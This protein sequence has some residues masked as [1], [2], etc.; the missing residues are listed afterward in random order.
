MDGLFHGLQ[1]IALLLA[2]LIGLPN[3]GFSQQDNTNNLEDETTDGSTN[4]TFGIATPQPWSETSKFPVIFF[5]CLSLVIL[6]ICA[7]GLS[8]CV[9]KARANARPGRRGPPDLSM[10]FSVVLNQRLSESLRSYSERNMDSGIRPVEF[11]WEPATYE[12]KLPM[13]PPYEEINTF[14]QKPDLPP[15]Y[16]DSIK[17]SIS[18][19]KINDNSHA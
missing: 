9:R 6:L 17:D 11:P 19:D 2:V 3:L 14:Q 1:R 7:V 4:V 18:A 12:I 10:V 15:S 8:T 13:P 5:S 16:S